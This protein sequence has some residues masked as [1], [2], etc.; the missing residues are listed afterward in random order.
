MSTVIDEIASERARQVSAEGWTPEH[1]DEHN[2][3]AMARAAA[4]YAL[5]ADPLRAFPVA[6]KRVWVPHPGADEL[7]RAQGVYK[8]VPEFWPWHPNW[9]KPKGQRA[10]LIRAAA[11]LVAEIERIDRASAQAE[12][13][14][15]QEVDRT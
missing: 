5:L 11:L 9:W 15:K 7:S 13:R 6:H 3:A 1:D 14:S 10:N 4:C 2:D 12:A 8:D